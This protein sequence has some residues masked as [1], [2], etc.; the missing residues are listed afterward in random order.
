MLKIHG[1][2][3]YPTKKSKN[4]DLIK[5]SDRKAFTEYS[6]DIQVIYKN[7]EKYNLNRQCNVLLVYGDM[8][9]NKKT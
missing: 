8:L 7:I 5:L 9:S 1:K 4:I 3:Q 6:N 2:Y